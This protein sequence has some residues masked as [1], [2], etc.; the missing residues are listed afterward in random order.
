MGR[1]SLFDCLK[2]VPTHAFTSRLMYDM[3][4]DQTMDVGNT[5]ALLHL[6]LDA[7]LLIVA[8]INLVCHLLRRSKPAAG[9]PGTGK[10]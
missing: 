5:I 8:I 3:K 2:H 1:E 7:A 4:G 10:D 6:I 9:T